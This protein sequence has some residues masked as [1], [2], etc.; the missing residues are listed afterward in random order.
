MVR[1]EKKIGLLRRRGWQQAFRG[2]LIT[3]AESVFFGPEQGCQMVY[4]RTKN[5][6]LGTFWRALEWETLLHFMTIWNILWPLGTIYGSLLSF[7][8]IWYNFSHFG[9]FGP[10]KIWQPWTRAVFF[11][12]DA[13][14]GFQPCWFN[15]LGLASLAVISTAAHSHESK[16]LVFAF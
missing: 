2:P 11:V 5:T 10:R 8:V 4:L 14:N 16:L 3:K 6:N 13:S 9:M 1:L 15:Q 7:L 12:T